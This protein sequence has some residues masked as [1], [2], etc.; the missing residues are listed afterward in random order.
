VPTSTGTEKKS[1]FSAPFHPLRHTL[2][3]LVFVTTFLP[4]KKNEIKRNKKK[5]KQKK[6][7]SDERVY[8]PQYLPP[9]QQQKKIKKTT[10]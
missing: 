5:G 7:W 6:M 3:A 10:R 4:Q 2:S 1:L 9:G 8:G